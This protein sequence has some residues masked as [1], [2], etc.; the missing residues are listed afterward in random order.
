MQDYYRR[1][2]PEEKCLL[3]EDLATVR[4]HF[5]LNSMSNRLRYDPINFIPLCKGC[6]HKAHF[7][8]SNE[9]GAEIG[10]IMGEE[11]LDALKEAKKEHLTITKKFLDKIITQYE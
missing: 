3:C 2:F 6:H 9:V 4:H 7:S 10:Q 1:E 5:I 11:W 8:S